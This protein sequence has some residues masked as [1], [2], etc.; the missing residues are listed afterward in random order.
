MAGDEEEKNEEQQEDTEGTM[1]LEIQGEGEPPSEAVEETAEPA[2]EQVEGEGQGE[3]DATV[4]APVSETESS[5][6][7]AAGVADEAQEQEAPPA[8]AQPLKPRSNVYTLLLILTFV[9]FSTIIFLVAK[10]AN[11]MYRARFLIMK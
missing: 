3:V 10:N 7:T 6:E 9:V 1:P 5:E 2:Q 4:E 11:E 8:V